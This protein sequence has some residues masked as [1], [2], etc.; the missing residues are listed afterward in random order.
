M[1]REEPTKGPNSQVL[2]R[3]DICSTDYI[4]KRK[5]TERQLA[6]RGYHECKS[7][8]SRRAGKKTA[9]K[10]S[11]T[12]SEWYSGKGNPACRPGVGEKIAAARRGKPMSDYQRASLKVPK[13]KTDLIREAAN[14]PEERERRSRLM[15][16]RLAAGYI[17]PG[18]TRGYAKNSKTPAPVLCRSNLEV[19]FLEHAEVCPA[20]ERIESAE[21]MAVL[22]HYQDRDRRYLPDFRV[23]TRTG[24]VWIVEIKGI[25]WYNDPPKTEA[26]MAAL[27]EV[28]DLSGWHCVILYTEAEMRSWLGLLA[29]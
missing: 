17:Q 22:Y 29:S 27:K 6:E 12:Y 20:V 26:K 3:C 28:C 14:R 23:T 13:K 5:T 4:G 19:K 24:Q 8:S 11:A 2:M 1:Y 7:C 18:P 10:M 25:N 9:A 16:E 15:S 21:K